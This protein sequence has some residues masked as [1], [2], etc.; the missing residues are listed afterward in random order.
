MGFKNLKILLEKEKR[1]YLILAIWL[2]IGYTVFEFVTSGYFGMVILL[3]LVMTCFLYFLLALF[4][5]QKLAQKPVLYLLICALLSYPVSVILLRWGIIII[6]IF[7]MIGI[8]T[9]IPIMKLP[10]ETTETNINK[11]S[12]STIIVNAPIL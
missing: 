11:L 3:L 2:L 10:I 7:F 8:F 9:H 1:A 4:S 12:R 6:A 5:K